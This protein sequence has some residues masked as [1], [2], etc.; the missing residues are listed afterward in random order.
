MPPVGDCATRH[1][2]AWAKHTASGRSI[3]AANNEAWASAAY[4]AD[5]LTREDCMI[6]GHR[7]RLPRAVCF[8]KIGNRPFI[9]IGFLS[10]G[11]IMEVAERI[12]GNI[13]EQEVPADLPSDS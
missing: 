9:P 12:P 13:R 7:N 2:H 4:S 10:T 1:G 6:D 8:V 5:W 3:I 11:T